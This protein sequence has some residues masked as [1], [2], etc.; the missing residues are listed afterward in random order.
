MGQAVF[1][2]GGIGAGNINSATFEPFGPPPF[3]AA[4]R[5]GNPFGTTREDFAS[6][7]FGFRQAGVANNPSQARVEAAKRRAINK[8][9]LLLG[10][11]RLL[12]GRQDLGVQGAVGGLSGP[13]AFRS[14]RE[15]M[16][17]RRQAARRD[18]Q[19]NKSEKDLLGDIEDN[20]KRM[21]DALEPTSS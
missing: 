15:A 3:L 19:E 12:A 7:S 10:S 18:Q 8:G 6:F 14:K 1:L 9:D 2:G 21:A 17:A 13:S 4:G 5:V 16:E 20:T 11:R